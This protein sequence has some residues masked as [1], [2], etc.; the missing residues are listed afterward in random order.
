MACEIEGTIGNTRVEGEIVGTCTVGMTGGMCMEGRIEKYWVLGS[1]RLAV[2]EIESPG[3]HSVEE[4]KCFEL[5]STCFT[6]HRKTL[7]KKRVFLSFSS[8]I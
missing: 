5:D 6:T 4:G 2:I 3:T 1:Q 7:A 8:Y